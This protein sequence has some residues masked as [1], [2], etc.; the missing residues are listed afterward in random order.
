MCIIARDVENCANM[1][2]ELINLSLWCLLIGRAASLGSAIIKNQCNSDVY[3]QI[4]VGGRHSHETPVQTIK[5]GHQF[6][7]PLRLIW[8]GGTSVKLSLSSDMAEITQFEYTITDQIYYDISNVNGHPFR[9]WGMEI[10]PTKAGCAKRICPPGVA[11]CAE[12][13]N[14]PHDDW[15]VRACSPDTD[16]MFIACDTSNRRSGSQSAVSSSLQ[17]GHTLGV[18][19]QRQDFESIRDTSTSPVALSPSWDG[20]DAN[21]AVCTVITTDIILTRTM[22]V[23]HTI[24]VD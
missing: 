4:A 5:A 19:S 11:L 10:V 8:L 18:E 24:E 6:S 15:V 3:M 17:E 12:A 9:R 2:T 20:Q 21:Q 23:T 7:E 14:A 13:Y 1:F 16:L 22:D